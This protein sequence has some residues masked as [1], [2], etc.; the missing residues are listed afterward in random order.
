MQTVLSGPLGVVEN[1]DPHRHL[2]LRKLDA[3]ALLA[4]DLCGG[5]WRESR[6]RV[7]IQERPDMTAC[8]HCAQDT[9][10]SI[11]SRG[12]PCPLSTHLHSQTVTQQT[13]LVHALHKQSREDGLDVRSEGGLRT[14]RAMGGRVRWMDVSGGT[15]HQDTRDLGCQAPCCPCAHTLTFDLYSPGPDDLWKTRCDMPASSGFSSMDGSRSSLCSWEKS[16]ASYGS[17]ETRVRR[18]CGGGLS[19]PLCAA[20][21]EC[22]EGP[23]GRPPSPGG[24]LR[25]SSIDLFEPAL[26]RGTQSGA[27]GV[28]CS[29]TVLSSTMVH[30]EISQK[31]Y[32]VGEVV[33]LVV[34]TDVCRI[35]SLKQPECRK[36]RDCKPPV[37]S[38]PLIRP[39]HTIDLVLH[40]P[41]GILRRHRDYERNDP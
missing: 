22:P 13:S 20:R 1:P 18:L 24:Y 3:G 14:R 4:N 29:L 10:E 34:I 17:T 19:E 16:R 36:D 7:K 39:G 9:Y 12:G 31:W 35:R 23:G 15:A 8:S 11:K 28:R 40:P 33:H 32:L 38:S 26:L 21:P 30:F 27:G 25:F 5:E 41:R 2:E 6:P 37:L